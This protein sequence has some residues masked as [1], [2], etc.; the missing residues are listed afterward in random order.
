MFLTKP[1]NWY[2]F[3]EQEAKEHIGFSS[4]FNDVS[5]QGLMLFLHQSFSICVMYFEL[6][7]LPFIRIWNCNA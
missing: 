5:Q 1:K 2:K 3:I 4:G 7:T 6:N